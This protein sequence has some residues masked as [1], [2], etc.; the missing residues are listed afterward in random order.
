M[1]YYLINGALLVGILGVSAFLTHWYASAYITCRNCGT[2]NA[3]RR[4]VC[5]KCGGTLHTNV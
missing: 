4:V 5:R 1:K 2:M 3:R